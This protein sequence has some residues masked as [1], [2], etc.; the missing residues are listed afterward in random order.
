[1]RLIEAIKLGVKAHRA[2]DLHK[3]THYY[4]EILKVDPNHPDANHNMGVL[5]GELGRWKEALPFF[6]KATTSK[7][8]NNQHWISYINALIK[9]DQIAI[10]KTEI[11]NANLKNF[12]QELIEKLRSMTVP[13]KTEIDDDLIIDAVHSLL[14]LY[15]AGQLE[16][17]VQQ[18]QTLV[19]KHPK[20]FLIWNILGAAHKG[21][22]ENDKALT[23]FQKV[24]E[25]N[26]E[27]A[28]A[29]NNIG[30][31]FDE[32][33]RFDEAL[34]EYN[35]A[36][37]L[38]PKYPEAYNN[39]G[40]IFVNQNKLED[41]LKSFSQAI[42]IKPDYAEALF[43][44]GMV[45][46]KQGKWQEALD[47][48][49]TATTIKPDYAQS[50][51]EIGTILTEQGELEEALDAYNKAITVT[52]DCF[53]TYNNIGNVLRRQ[54]KL[55]AALVAY[56]KAIFL[57]PRFSR[58]YNNMGV[59]FQDQGNIEA[60]VH[61]Y[62]RA[63]SIEPDYSQA[64]KNFL[65]LPMGTLSKADVNVCKN[66]LVKTRE[67]KEKSKD[68]LFVE[69][70][71]LK[72]EGLLDKAFEK[73]C[74]AN[75]QKSKENIKAIE[76]ERVSRGQSLKR[77]QGWVPNL[78]DKPEKTLTK[79]FLVGPSRS[80]KS[81]LEQSLQKSFNVTAHYEGIRLSVL[82]DEFLKNNYFEK[83]IF[84]TLFYE[85][86]NAVSEKY[87]VI[88]S[89][90]PRS[91]F[92]ADYIF[93]HV[94]NSYFLYVNRPTMDIASEIFTNF[95]PH[96][97]FY[98]LSPNDIINYLSTYKKI[99]DQIALK[100]PDKCLILNWTD[101]IRS[102]VREIAKISKLVNKKI[103]TRSLKSGEYNFSVKSHFRDNFV[104]FKDQMPQ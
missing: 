37:L 58:A 12:S 25:L 76:E 24:I 103:Q 20:A 53:L 9:L 51:N 18:C 47:A 77:I 97:N 44:K 52:S 66:A 82:S 80:G 36:L 42:L 5:R 71:L 3:A 10:A 35:K 81:S 22:D 70:N 4:S 79:L 8:P 74:F 99:F 102:P 6:K 94:P 39:I 19:K 56:K 91:I 64:A 49:N 95:Y 100:V 61:C 2:G 27:F 23:E 68:F 60:S 32:Q 85:K 26:P 31:I 34:A 62:K 69:A 29:H 84:R 104:N 41:A 98:A 55:D 48:H 1:M 50:Y 17:V 30:I 40:T 11:E 90:N 28:E 96:G 93:D 21:L 38:K 72:H 57:E 45:L 87:E 54:G 88:T 13:Q 73:F 92:Y 59:A 65:G 75:K 83:D 67:S 15:N 43:N 86:E 33:G 7:T 46:K 89:T 78:P 16:T 63:L 14:A 101:V